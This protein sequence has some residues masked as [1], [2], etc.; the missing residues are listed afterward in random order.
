M[1]PEAHRMLTIVS[2]GV[3]AAL[4]AASLI[5]QHRRAKKQE[6]ESQGAPDA[7]PSEQKPPEQKP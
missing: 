6:A 7:P 2:G 3:M 1:E 4:G 5:I